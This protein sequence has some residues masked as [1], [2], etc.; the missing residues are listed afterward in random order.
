MLF[1]SCRKRDPSWRI[2]PGSTFLVREPSDRSQI[3][4][5][6]FGTVRGWIVRAAILFRYPASDD[7][8]ATAHLDSMRR[9]YG[10]ERDEP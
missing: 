1:A 7:A 4:Y 2:V 6:P 9:A 3:Q 10:A 5:A 8:C